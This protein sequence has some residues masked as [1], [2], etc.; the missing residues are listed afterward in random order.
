ML[1]K[2]WH[3]F[4]VLAILSFT[5][6]VLG[7]VWFLNNFQAT[8][9]AREA[10]RAREAHTLMVMV[11][12]QKLLS[13][14]Q[15][16]ETG[17]RGY[18]LTGDP[19]YLEPYNAARQRAAPQF[20]ALRRL[21]ADNPVQRAR[22]AQL[23]VLGDA[24][25]NDFAK[26]KDFIDTGDTGAAETWIRNGSGKATM[27]QM[28]GVI[29]QVS[30]EE[31]RLLSIRRA[32][33]LR[34]TDRVSRLTD[35]AKLAGALLV[36]IFGLTIFQLM[37]FSKRETEAR[38]AAQTARAVLNSH[39]LLQTVMDSS[40]DPVYVKDTE[41]RFVFVNDSALNLL[42]GDTVQGAQQVIG[43]RDRDFL[44]L[45][46]A[47]PL[48]RVDRAVMTSGEACTA[49]EHVPRNGEMR[50]FLSAKVPWRQD[51]HIVGMIGISRD[52][53][54]RVTIENDLR[55][56]SAEL[57]AR[58]IRRTSELSD[59]LSRLQSEA[60]DRER[61]ETQ[62]RQ[63]QKLDSIG[64]LTGGIAHDFNNMLSIIFGSLEMAKRRL[65]GAEHERVTLGI[66]NAYEGA[67]RAASLTARLLA[68]SRQQPLEP[69]VIDANKLVGNTSE[70]LQRTLGD[71][72]RLETVLAGGLW[73]IF[74]DMSQI[75]NA[76][77]NLAVNARDSMTTG[78]R[79]T[80]ETNNTHLDEN[81]A[82]DHIEVTAGQYV[83]ICVSDTGTGMTAEV[84]DRVF[85]PFFTTKDVGKGTGLGMSQVFGFI[86]QSGGH[87]KIY[88][89]IGQGST[90]KI[91]LPRHFGSAVAV[92]E[93]L[94][95]EM[96]RG[97]ASEV[98]L[99]VEDED[100][101]REI[102]AASLRELGYCVIDSGTPADALNLVRTRDDI[103]LLFTDIMMAEMTGRQLADQAT[104]IRP[105]L[106][107]LYTTGYTR[108]AVVHNGMLD[109]GVAF[110][111]KP[112]TTAD[113]ARKVRAVIDGLGINRQ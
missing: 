10:S 20:Q 40:S 69:S 55:T 105:D 11:A 3:W 97:H 95:S 23:H 79:L 15:D 42:V 90:I 41:G 59:A 6:F 89:E 58:V 35:A 8:E 44:P 107:T 111:A 63:I 78:G 76:L 47:E 75:E 48:E 13:T 29:A 36:A 66:N 21:T 61:A 9:R 25:L 24:L 51:G 30:G 110:L 100:K 93:P 84:I 31:E 73:P 62:L 67:S 113:L 53:T 101:V 80:I 37:R 83:A 86:K 43:K 102:A 94:A 103:L 112:Y 52:I 65:T 60:E 17:Q 81:Y 54:D 82:R 68:F 32:D 27:D 1:R 74:A 104:G 19:D 88:S 14:Y 33:L 34:V 64:Q 57:D 5:L 85:D 12:T 28:R 46:I 22:T 16:A 108:N 91:Y 26:A 50:I 39:N 2:K 71:D 72:I 56:L 49:D 96:P 87:I 18:L 99:V 38:I 77:V 106:K 45:D 70:L 4:D 7:A 109:I 98:I 92:K